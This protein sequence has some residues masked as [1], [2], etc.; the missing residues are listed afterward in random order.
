MLSKILN[1]ITVQFFNNFTKELINMY[2]QKI[3]INLTII[4]SAN[5]QNLISHINLLK[6]SYKYNFHINK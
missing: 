5:D 6:L 3:F 1:T 4:V 2:I